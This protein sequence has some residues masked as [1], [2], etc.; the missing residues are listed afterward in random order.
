MPEERPANTAGMMGVSAE[1][2]ILLPEEPAVLSKSKAL[3]NPTSPTHSKRQKQ[4]APSP[5]L[6][7]I[8]IRL[9]YTMQDLVYLLAIETYQ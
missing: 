7:P 4:I 9:D 5:H 8:H 3:A 1:S 6:A 2:A